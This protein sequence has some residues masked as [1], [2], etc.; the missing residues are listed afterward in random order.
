MHHNRLPSEAGKAG[1]LSTVP[2]TL[3]SL[4]QL[5]PGLRP[6]LPGAEPAPRPSAVI[7]VVAERLGHCMTRARRRASMGRYVAVQWTRS[8]PVFVRPAGSCLDS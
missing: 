8:T 1:V 3:S 5:G 2:A 4:Q 7:L 6:L